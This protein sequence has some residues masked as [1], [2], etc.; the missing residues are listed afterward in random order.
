MVKQILKF[1]SGNLKVQLFL[2]LINYA[3]CHK[4]EWGNAGI[5]PSFLRLATDG[6]EWSVS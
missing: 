4:D 1:Y 6:S 5:A 3:P 2:G